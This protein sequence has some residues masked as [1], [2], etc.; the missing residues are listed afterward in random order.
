MSGHSEEK[1]TTLLSF[2]YH[3]FLMVHFKL[4]QIVGDELKTK[5][6]CSI[7]K[8]VEA[9]RKHLYRNTGKQSSMKVAKSSLESTRDVWVPISYHM[10]M[11]VSGAAASETTSEKAQRSRLN[12]HSI[13]RWHQQQ[14]CSHVPLYTVPMPQQH[15]SPG[16]SYREREVLP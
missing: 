15:E 6:L 5:V 7:E 11:N 13:F 3:N 1:I 9:E 16:A 2:P 4:V 12:K 8:A 10:F 14:E